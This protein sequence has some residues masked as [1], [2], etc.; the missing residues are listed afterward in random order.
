MKV[1]NKNLGYFEVLLDKDIEDYLINNNIKLYIK[2]DK[3]NLVYVKFFT[4]KPKMKTI[5]LHR[6]ITNCPDNMVVDHI[7]HNTLDNRRCNLKVCT[8]FDNN[9]NTIMNTSGVTG[10]H[11]RKDCNK[12]YAHIRI[13]KKRIHLGSYNSKEEAIEARQKAVTSFCLENKKK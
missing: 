10:V 4:Y 3:K 8:I 2:Q 6:F 1:F 11:Y 7:N 5:L 9:N 12:W 13:N